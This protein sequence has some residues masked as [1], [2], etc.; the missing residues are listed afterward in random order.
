MAAGPV[1]QH[2]YARDRVATNLQHHTTTAQY[3]TYAAVSDI[4]VTCYIV[5]NICI[6]RDVLNGSEMPSHASLLGPYPR[7]LT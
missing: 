5:C 6:A 7:D 1:A 3:R 2:H 4:L